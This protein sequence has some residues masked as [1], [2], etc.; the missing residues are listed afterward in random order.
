MTGGMVAGKETAFARFHTLYFDRLFRYLLVVTGGDEQ[1]ALDGVQETLLRV[2]RHV[3]AFDSD[4]ALWSWLTVL[5]RSAARDGARRRKSYLNMVAGYAKRFFGLETASPP[6]ADVEGELRACLNA[7]LEALE[8]R[9]RLLVEEKYF[10][11]KSVKELAVEQGLSVKAVESRLLRARR[12]LKK[13]ISV[14][15]EDEGIRF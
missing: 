15:L 12:A 1:A 5:A 14:L 2:V 8:D 13:Q 9:D 11:G 7:S 4:E 6:V 10:G 3:R